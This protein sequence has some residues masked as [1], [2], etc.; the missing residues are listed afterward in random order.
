M[1][2]KQEKNEMVEKLF[3]AGAH[4]AYA[5]SRRHPSMKPFIFGV[6]NKV[7]IFDLEKTKEMLEKAVAFV[8][9]VASTN[10]Q[11][12]FLGGKNESREAV[13][14][15]ALSVAMPYVSGRWIGGTLTNFSE[16]KKRIL[17]LETLTTQKEKGE[18][19]KYTK[20][21]RLLI[22]REIENLKRF[23]GGLSVMRDLPKALFVVDAKREHIALAEAKQ[24][25]VPVISLMNSDNN[26][27]DCEYPIP[28]NDASVS[29]IKF[30]ATELAKAYEKGKITAKA[31]APAVVKPAPAVSAVKVK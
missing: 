4:F 10:G 26:F 27:K 5:K 9:S 25:G 2:A 18:L 21:E 8:S 12:L 31:S 3:K 20:K 11:V 23:F 13:K 6:K 28:A 15:T 30:F 14:G 24:M 29:S 1:Q 19:G 22:D 16:I 17:K 7:E